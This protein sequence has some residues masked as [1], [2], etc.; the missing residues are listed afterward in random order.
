[1][2]E[3]RR[4]NVNPP[5]GLII[6]R[7]RCR[8]VSLDLGRSVMGVGEADEYGPFNFPQN[9]RSTSAPPRATD[10]GGG[11][12]LNALGRQ[13]RARPADATKQTRGAI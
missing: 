2:A 1:M 3:Q 6:T 12:P 4:F 8:I 5:V 13:K 7:V 10:F 11:Y 9:I